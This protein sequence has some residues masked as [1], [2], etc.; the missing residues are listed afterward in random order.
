M[1]KV[2]DRGGQNEQDR[3]RPVPVI[4]RASPGRRGWQMVLVR[5]GSRTAG[6]PRRV[7]SISGI[8][9]LEARAWEGRVKLW[10]WPRLTAARPGDRTL[11]SG[12]LARRL[13]SSDRPGTVCKARFEGLPGGP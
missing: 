10:R 9:N 12:G 2:P 13:P 4:H 11:R 6:R 5:A 7:N 3:D 1:A 8:A